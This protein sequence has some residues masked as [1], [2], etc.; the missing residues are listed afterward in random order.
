MAKRDEFLAAIVNALAKRASFIC[1]NPDCRSLTVA[2]SAEKPD[3]AIFVGKAAHITAAAPGGPRYDRSL[4]EEQRG[5]AENGIF[6]CSDCAT[7]I[8]C[9]GGADF[10]VDT[11]RAWKRN[12]EAWTCENLNKSRSALVTTIDGSHSARG[13]GEVTGL[14]V[15][16]P[17]KIMPGT[18]SSAEGV[19]RIT[20]TRIGPPRR[21]SE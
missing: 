14:D 11:L 9:N 3:K 18:R 6:L 5:A 1:S 19:G 2:A 12:H 20:G 15:Q 17:A 8:D 13:I 10:S 21:G 7:M 16:G 4:S